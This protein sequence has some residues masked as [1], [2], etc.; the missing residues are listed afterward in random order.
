[1]EDKKTEQMRE[2]LRL[3]RIQEE[4]ISDEMIEEVYNEVTAKEDTE[5]DER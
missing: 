4:D 1:M 2:Y 5:I 3:K